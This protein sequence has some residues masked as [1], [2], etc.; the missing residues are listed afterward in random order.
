MAI[1]LGVAGLADYF[2][3]W[4]IILGI[5][6]PPM[7]S[8]IIADYYVL[9]KGKYQF[10]SG[11]KYVGI[12]WPALISWILASVVGYYVKWGSCFTK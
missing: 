8:I 5:T 3:L 11:T 7:A 12:Y 9:K 10:G 1:L 6:I 4:L 2:V